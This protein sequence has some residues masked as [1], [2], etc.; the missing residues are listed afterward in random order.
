VN[1]LAVEE[2]YKQLVRELVFIIGCLLTI[3][4]VLASSGWIRLWRP[5]TVEW[6]EKSSRAQVEDRGGIVLSRSA[7]LFR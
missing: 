6:S 5:G 7:R 2:V 3:Q 4:G 1:V